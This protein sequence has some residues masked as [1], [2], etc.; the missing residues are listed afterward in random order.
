MFKALFKRHSSGLMVSST[1]AVF[2]PAT[3]FKKYTKPAHWT[4][5]GHNGG[6][7]LVITIGRKRTYVHRLVAETFLERIPGM[8]IVDHIDRDPTNN[9]V[10]NLRFT[11][12]Q[13]NMRNKESYE[14]ARIKL[15][16]PMTA[17]PKEVKTAYMFNRY[18]A[19]PEKERARKRKNKE[20]QP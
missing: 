1:G 14:Q 13:G 6:K 7:Y 18:W 15:G 5:G 19:D 4:Y 20:V 16:L 10:F 11:D 2:V 17:T 9:S 3:Q 8:D 12:T